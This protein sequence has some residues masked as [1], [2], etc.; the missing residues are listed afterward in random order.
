MCRSRS[1][2]PL[3]KRGEA[4]AGGAGGTE[5]VCLWSEH[6]LRSSSIWRSGDQAEQRDAGRLRAFVAIDASRRSSVGL[7]STVVTE[8]TAASNDSIFRMNEK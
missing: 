6:P 8:R 7:P 2:A 3:P 4:A 1:I 5:L